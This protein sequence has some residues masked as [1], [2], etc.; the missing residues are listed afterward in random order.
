MTG[1]SLTRT[2]KGLEDLGRLMTAPEV[3]EETFRDAVKV[4]KSRA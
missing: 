3:A 1:L 4:D 2:P